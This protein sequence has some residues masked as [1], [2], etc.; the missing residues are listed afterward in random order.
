MEKKKRGFLGLAI[1]SAL[2]IGI[3]LGLVWAVT[4]REHE[5]KRLFL[6]FEAYRAATALIEEFRDRG[7]IA[8][9]ARIISFGLYDLNGDQL[10]GSGAAPASVKLTEYQG[11]AIKLA[12]NG[13]SLIITRLVGGD[14]PGGQGMGGMMNRRPL[15]RLG[16]TGSQ[17]AP[18]LMFTSPLLAGP[19]AV[20]LE[21]DAGGF[22][23]DRAFLVGVSM[24]VSIAL[25]GFYVLMLVLFKRN[26]ELRDRESKNRELVELGEAARTLVHE[27]RNPLGIIRVHAGLLRRRAA[28]NPAVLDAAEVIDEEVERLSA[29]SE[30]IREFLK[31]GEG[32][33]RLINLSGFFAD[34]AARRLPGYG[35]TKATA[36]RPGGDAWVVADPERLALALDNLVRNAREANPEAEPELSLV[37]KG[38]YWEIAVADRG[39]GVRG[40]AATR[41]FEPFF[42][43]KE[44]GS[45]IGLALAR[46]IA[47]ASGGSLEYRERSGGGALFA[48]ALP[49]SPGKN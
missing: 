45:G 6:E 43:T 34:F 1:A 40:E 20:Y 8:G 28:N 9:A 25:M 38:K 33:P 13:K 24:I 37:P 39:P 4:I 17:N 30:R 35:P 47:V 36:S 10:A 15:R 12:E 29:L 7:R 23:Q 3:I 21:Y 19:R 22:P 16:G 32:E 18:P 5:T 31:G 2:G 27:I 14:M 46:R 48:I 26:A 11:G 44:N 42:T 41:L 49:A